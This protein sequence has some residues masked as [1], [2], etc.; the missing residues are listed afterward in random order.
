MKVLF[1]MFSFTT[2]GR[3][4]LKV[5]LIIAAAPDDPLKGKEPFMPI[6]LGLL[7]ASAPDYEYVFTDMLRGEKVDFTEKVDVVGISMRITAE[8]TAYEVAAPKAGLP[9]SPAALPSP[10]GTTAGIDYLS[11]DEFQGIDMESQDPFEGI[12]YNSQDEFQGEDE[13]QDYEVY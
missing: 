6:S 9:T 5:K 11:Q 7:A 12:D 3:Q 10:A 2:L 8:K 1:P 4:N 13:L